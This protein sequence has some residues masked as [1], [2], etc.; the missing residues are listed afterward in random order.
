[1]TLSEAEK[2]H[3]YARECLRLA[4]AV[5]RSDDRE[6]LVELSRLWMEAALREARRALEGTASK[7]AASSG[8]S[9]SGGIIR[10]DAVQAGYVEPH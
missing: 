10:H 7:T 5:D 4:E 3:I 8:I 6:K 9:L 2:Y 1:M